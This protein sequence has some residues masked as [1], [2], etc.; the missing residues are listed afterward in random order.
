[1]AD[2]STRRQ[3]TG[4]L[5]EGS[6]TLT[7]DVTL[8]EAPQRRAEVTE[9]EVEQGINVSDHV[10]PQAVELQCDVVVTATPTSD[11]GDPERDRRWRDDLVAMYDAAELVTVTC[12]HGVYRSMAIA[13]FSE[14]IDASTGLALIGSITF[15]QV[16]VV[17]RR[18]E[19]LPPVERRVARTDGGV[20]TGETETGT[21]GY[22]GLDAVTQDLLQSTTPDGTTLYD[23]VYRPGEVSNRNDVMRASFGAG[24]PG[25]Q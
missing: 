3:R 14:V 25:V 16:R 19:L 13:E 2:L 15:K 6:R 10:R 21:P 5:I 23:L 4:L 1:M 12:E 8:R 7:A 11:E 18:A 24:A 9:H 20:A 17:E 22:F